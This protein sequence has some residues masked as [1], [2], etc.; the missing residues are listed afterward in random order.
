MK[1]AVFLDLDDTVLDFHRAED[2]ALRQTLRSFGVTPDDAM[3]ARY[4]AVNDAQW[5]RLERGEI[6]REEVLV[7]RFRLF[8]EELGIALDP[9][10]ARRA[11]EENVRNTGFLLPGAT[12]LLE[13]LSASYDLYAA[14]N[15]TARVQDGRIA[16]AGIAPYFKKIFLSERVGFNKPDKRFFERCF[17]ELPHLSP[18]RTPM[19][20]DS[21]SSDI[22]GGKNAGMIT[23]W[24]N[25]HGKTADDGLRPDYEVTSLD[26]IPAVLAA[27]FSAQRKAETSFAGSR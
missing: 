9:F 2:Y 8:F 13:E 20:G 1:P 11:Y 10:A 14:S 17:A 22:R 7:G 4:S 12:A 25:P 15:G 16:R 5:K 3:T 21:L 19:V 24:Y 26:G 27:V 18:E 23:V 6:T